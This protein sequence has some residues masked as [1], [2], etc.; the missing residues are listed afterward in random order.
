MLLDESPPKLF[1]SVF[2]VEEGFWRRRIL[3]LAIIALKVCIMRDC[4]LVYDGNN[5]KPALLGVENK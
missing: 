4:V 5:G 1:G 2:V 3:P